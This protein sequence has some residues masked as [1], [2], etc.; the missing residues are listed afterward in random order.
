MVRAVGG[1]IFEDNDIFSRY[2]DIFPKLLLHGVR[3]R[4]AR[5]ALS[6]TPS[7]SPY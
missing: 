5:R 7:T 1:A 3:S 6:P 4:D 2:L